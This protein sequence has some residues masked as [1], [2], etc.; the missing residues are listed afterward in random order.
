M[1]KSFTPM[2][3]LYLFALA[4]IFVITCKYYSPNYSTNSLEG[5]WNGSLKV[6]VKGGV[7]DGM[8]SYHDFQFVFNNDGS[9]VFMNPSPC[10]LTKIGSL[11]V[12]KDGDIS[13][14]ITTSHLNNYTESTYINWDGS[15]F[16]CKLKIIVNINCFWFI[17]DTNSN[18][19]YF[20]TGLLTKSCK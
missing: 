2:F 16:D 20:I 14:V 4:L 3:I 19:Y 15:S 12:S 6:V 10:F 7:N 5:V 11:S 1:K 9:L 13:G 17:T 18:G 8:E